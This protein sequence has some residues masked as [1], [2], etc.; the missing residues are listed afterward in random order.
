MGG[1]DYKGNVHYAV[2]NAKNQTKFLIDA[3][4]KEVREW[5]PDTVQ[6]YN[7]EDW[8]N[9]PYLVNGKRFEIC[10]NLEAIK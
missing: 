2:F 5:D 7:F 3:G 8:S 4:F 10:L 1:Q 6:N 9:R